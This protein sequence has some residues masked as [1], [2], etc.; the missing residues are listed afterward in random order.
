MQQRRGP[1]ASKRGGGKGIEKKVVGSP[2]F[3]GL[4]GHFGRL[5]K[6]IQKRN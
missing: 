2:S 3:D 6:N 5:R 1:H 4:K